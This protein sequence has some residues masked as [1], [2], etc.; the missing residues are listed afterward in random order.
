MGDDDYVFGDDDFPSAEAGAGDEA[1][2]I[3]DPLAMLGGMGAEELYKVTAVA[4]DAGEEEEA[5][6]IDDPLAMLGGMGAE[7]LYKVTAMEEDQGEETTKAAEEDGEP[8][9]DIKYGC[10][11]PDDSPLTR[12]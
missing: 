10:A 11:T 1:A 8:Y 2:D 4:E 9:P 6:D 12:W 5:G 7:E 3:D